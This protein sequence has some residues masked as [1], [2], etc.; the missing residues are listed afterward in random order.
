M[1]KHC[2]C[3]PATITRKEVYGCVLVCWDCVEKIY[4]VLRGRPYNGA[5]QG[6]DAY[7]FAK[8][9]DRLKAIAQV[10]RDNGACPQCGEFHDL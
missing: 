6:Y 2:A 5:R 10:R 7:G 9:S 8:E 4:I 3:C 1:A